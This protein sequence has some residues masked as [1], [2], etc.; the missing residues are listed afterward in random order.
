MDLPSRIGVGCLGGGLGCLAG[1]VP[2]VLVLSCLSSEEQA[3]GNIF[4]LPFAALGCLLGALL[5]FGVAS[6]TDDT[7]ES[8]GGP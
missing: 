4:V 6:D 8:T 7:D 1:A 2:P 3:Q 5:A